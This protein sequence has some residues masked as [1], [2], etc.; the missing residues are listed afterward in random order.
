MRPVAVVS[1]YL[2]PVDQARVLDATGRKVDVIHAPDEAAALA[3]VRDRRAGA[4]I[5]GIDGRNAD[6]AIAV[7][8]RVREAFATIPVVGYY[9]A[10]GMSG[11]QLLRLAEARLTDLVVRGQDDLRVVFAAIL[12]NAS[13]RAVAQSLIDAIGPALPVAAR[14]ILEFIIAHAD[15]RFTVEEAAR[16]L[17]VS[18]RTLAKRLAAHRLP[19][20]ETLMGWCRLLLAAHLLEDQGRTVDDVAAAL[21]FGTANN[22]RNMLRRYAGCSPAEVREQGA[23]KA[24]ATQFSSKIGVPVRTVERAIGTQRTRRRRGAPPPAT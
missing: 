13:R 3:A 16:A 15:E 17:G 11:R 9:H 5:V 1:L 7:A 23:I 19:A 14:P 18:R 22:L 21:D 2:S 24:V 6:D 4:V 10:A 20:P 8:R 12:A